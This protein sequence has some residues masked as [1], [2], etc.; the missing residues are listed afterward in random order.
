MC[1]LAENKRAVNLNCKLRCPRKGRV[2]K[3]K[4]EGSMRRK[5][6]QGSAG[7]EL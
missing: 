3:V 6:F 7:D 2:R 4:V 5:D 1:D